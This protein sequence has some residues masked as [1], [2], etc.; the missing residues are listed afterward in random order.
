MCVSATYS[1]ASPASRAASAVTGPTEAIR[2]LPF[3]PSRLRFSSSLRLTTARTA[4]ALV[5]IIQSNRRSSVIAASSGAKS[6]GFAKDTRGITTGI[7]PWAESS[8]AR[9]SLCAAERVMMMRFPAKA[10]G[11]ASPTLP[12]YFFQDGL[13]ARLDEHPRHVFSKLCRLVGRSG[14]AL[15]HVLHS[16]HGTNA[17][18]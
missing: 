4:C 12:A 10:V 9:A 1:T 8:R 11:G 16:V 3:G 14:D 5:R 15:L 7:A 13:R 2:N 17:G 6:S 18:I